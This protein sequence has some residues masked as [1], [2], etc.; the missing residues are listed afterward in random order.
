MTREE[1]FEAWMRAYE[2]DVLRTCLVLLC[3]RSLAE[4]ALQETFLKVWRHMDGY[5]GRNRASVRTWIL[6]I[7]LNTCRDQRKS[8]WFRRQRENVPVEDVSLPSADV[9]QEAREMY[10]DVQRLQDRLKEAV[11][12]H[13]YHQLTKVETAETLRISR[14]ALDRR[15]HKAYAAL[16]YSREEVST[17]EE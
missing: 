3:D 10:I 13:H 12:L 11:V 5:E 6:Q 2:H 8:S 17:D 1:R 9:P 4:D 7:A 16:G 14:A 15:L